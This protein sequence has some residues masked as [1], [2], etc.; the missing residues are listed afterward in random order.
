MSLISPSDQD[1]AK[2][3]S[4]TLEAVTAAIS[5]TQ[6]VLVQPLTLAIK[7]AVVVAMTPIGSALQDLSAVLLDVDVPKLAGEAA[8]KMLDE[9]EGLTVTAT[10]TLTVTRKK[11][12]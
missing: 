1:V 8:G 3:K 9:L 10:V 5:E 2:I 11:V 7:D 12:S 4:A 6:R